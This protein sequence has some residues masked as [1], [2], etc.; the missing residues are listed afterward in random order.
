MRIERPGNGDLAGLKGLWREAFQ[1][2]EAFL[3]AFFETAYA[4]ERCRCVKAEDGTVAAALYWLD[5]EFAGQ[6]LAYVYAVATGREFRGQGLCRKLMG[7]TH[8][9][10]AE[11]GYAGALLRPADAGLR[12]MYAGMGYVDCCSVSEISCEAGEAVALRRIGGAEYGRLRRELLPREGVVQEGESLALLERCAD[13]YAGEDFL[14]A[15]VSEGEELRG[16]E[17]LGNELAAPGVLAALGFE[18][19]RFRVPGDG[20]G[21]AMFRGLRDGVRVPGYLGLVFD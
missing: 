14:L 7:E 16:M 8:R 21:F 13:L 9:V 17:L 19:G 3:V 10:L 12:E 15:A 11:Q 18:S 20:E 2:E 5:A 1:E 4:P 6:K